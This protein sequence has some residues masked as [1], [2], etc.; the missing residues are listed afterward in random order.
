[1]INATRS[2]DAVDVVSYLLGDERLPFTSC[3][4]AVS[5][6]KAWGRTASAASMQKDR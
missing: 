2:D 3:A 4:V 1:M 5:E 6:D